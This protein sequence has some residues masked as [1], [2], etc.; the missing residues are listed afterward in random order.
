MQKIFVCITMITILAGGCSTPASGPTS[1]PP[2]TTATSLFG[3]VDVTMT[4]S[5]PAQINTEPVVM[6]EKCRN[7][8]YP[9]RNDAW[10]MYN[11]SSGIKPSQT[12]AVGND[13]AFTVTVQNGDVAFTFKGQCT[14]EGV[15]LL[16]APGAAASLLGEDNSSMLTAQNVG[17]VTLPN[18]VQAGDNWSQRI[19]ITGGNITATIE[20][21][22]HAVGYETVNV[23]A[24]SFQ[25]LKVE[26][27][28]TVTLG[29]QVFNTYAILWYTQDVGIVKSVV[30]DITAELFAY[31]FP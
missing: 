25:A 22:Y 11:M 19:D 7:R 5:A 31:N 9:V 12:M 6:Y 26:Q 2:E 30:G 10:W 17:G 24:G 15:V 27:N 28:G 29:G 1:P 16:E 23:P 21:N 18:D 8:F 3:T 20:T 13:N 4:E 14:E